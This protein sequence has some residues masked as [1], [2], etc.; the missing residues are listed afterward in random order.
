MID[1]FPQVGEFSGAGDNLLL[2]L[3]SVGHPHDPNETRFMEDGL[4]NGLNPRTGRRFD[5][6][7]WDTVTR[8]GKTAIRGKYVVIDGAR[9]RQSDVISEVRG[10]CGECPVLLED[11]GR[12]PSRGTLMI[13]DREQARNRVLQAAV[14]VYD[15]E[16]I[17]GQSH[18]ES[19]S[20]A[21]LAAMASMETLS[22]GEISEEMIRAA[23][24]L[25]TDDG[26]V[27]DDG[28]AALL[29][30]ARELRESVPMDDR[31]E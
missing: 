26:D 5:A 24:L 1:A 7:M 13:T 9:R 27:A 21:L 11:L 14:A 30:F 31:V 20:A 12:A 10:I 17:L 22:V 28:V 29:W 15:T 6:R 2:D 25:D 23:E 16:V 3:P 4:C 18:A 19:L 8:N